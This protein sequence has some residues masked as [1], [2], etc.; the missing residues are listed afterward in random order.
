MSYNKN[1]AYCTDIWSLPFIPVVE[2]EE[3]FHDEHKHLLTVRLCC[4]LCVQTMLPQEWIRIAS[5]QIDV[6]HHRVHVEGI[7]HLKKKKTKQTKNSHRIYV[8]PRRYSRVKDW[9]EIFAYSLS[10]CLNPLLSTG[11]TESSWRKKHYGVISLQHFK[12][13]AA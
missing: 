5:P 7:K 2:N 1:R 9:L 10:Y 13:K 11:T 12:C 4:R 6:A 8:C 3:A